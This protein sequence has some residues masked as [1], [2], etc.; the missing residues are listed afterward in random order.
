MLEL[1]LSPDYKEASTQENQ[2][3]DLSMSMFAT[4]EELQQAREQERT[5]VTVTPNGFKATRLVAGVELAL[6]Q[7]GKRWTLTAKPRKA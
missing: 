3:S 5:Q 7:S 1:L 2:M 6:K 4:K